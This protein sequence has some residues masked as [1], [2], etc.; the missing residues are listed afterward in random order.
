MEKELKSRRDIPVELTW[1][2]S[3]LYATEEEMNRDVERAKALCNSIVKDYKGKLDTPQAIRACLDDLREFNRLVMLVGHYCDLAVSVDYYDTHNQERNEAFSSLTADMFSRLSFIDNEIAGQEDAVVQEAIDLSAENRNY[4]QNIL[5]M[6][7]HLLHPETE[8]AVA[9][10]SQTIQAPYQ[11]YNMAKLADMKFDNFT[12]DGREYPLGYSLFEDNYEYERD[13]A[14]R[15]SAFDAFSAKIREYE[16]VTAAA[17]NTQVQTEKTL[18]TLRGYDS[19][20]D[21]LLFGQKVTR[22][23]YN[24]QIDLITEKLAPHMRRYARLL[25]RIHKLDRMT[26]ADLKIAVDPEYDPKVTIE[27]SREYIEKGLA[28]LGE[29]Y[30]EMVREAYRDRWIDFAQ[31]QGKS[32]GGF[33]AS[34]YGKNSFILLSWNERMSDVFTLAHELG[35]AGHFKS[36]N[37]SQSIFDI[38]VSTYFVEAPSTMNELLMAHYLLK[39]NQEPRF[40]RWVL[41]CMISNTYYHNFVTHLMEAAYQREVYRIVDDGG[42]VNAETLTRLMR[43]TLQ[44]FWGEDVEISDDAA[45]T[46]MRQPHYYMGLYSYTYSAGLTVATQVCRRIEKE[47]ACAVEDWK[48]V[49]AAGSTLDPVGLAKLAGIDITTDEPLLDTI[50]YIGEIIDEIERL[51]DSGIGE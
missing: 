20:F 32:T 49:L 33:C 28:I 6:K 7:P 42:S 10:L 16:N 50:A 48:K 11:I 15:R 21:S 30:V 41:S 1:D 39:T 31:N 45:H 3:L 26:F 25:K 9:A 14:V 27:E 40:R 46:W 43:E 47:G 37:S 4:L 5:R 24:R 12:V 44:A 35:H 51:T 38:D 36:C 23:M 13:T 19:V 22:E 18:A 29:D 34:P 17:Y 2:L 8:R